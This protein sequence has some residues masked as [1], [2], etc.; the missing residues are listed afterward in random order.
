MVRGRKARSSAPDR[1]RLFPELQVDHER[2]QSGMLNTNFMVGLACV[3]AAVSLVRFAMALRAAHAFV[4]WHR[5]PLFLLNRTG[6]HAADGD[7]GWDH[8]DRRGWLALSRAKMWGTLMLL[9]FVAMA[10]VRIAG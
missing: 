8:V 10:L 2:D 6:P 3:V 1:V 9:S 7:S 4:A 5:M